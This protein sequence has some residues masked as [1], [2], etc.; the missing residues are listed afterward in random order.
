M[1]SELFGISAKHWTATES[2]V[3]LSSGL[4]FASAR[5]KRSEFE[6][7]SQFLLLATAFLFTAL[8]TT[9][10]SF[11]PIE[12][13]AKNISDTLNSKPASGLI[14]IVEIDAKSLQKLEKW[15][16]PRGYHAQLVDRL[17]EAGAA[18]IVFDVDFSSNSETTQ[19]AAFAAA[20]KRSQGRVV[21]PTFR[22]A[23]SSGHLTAEIESLP[24][25]SLREHAFLGAVNVHPD[26][27]GQVNSYPYGMIT[28]QTPRPSI[29]A[30]LAD[31]DGSMNASFKIDQSIEIDT[32][33]KHSFVD[34]LNNDFDRSDIKNKKIIVG[35]T[36]IEIGDRYP[37][38]RFGVIPGVI[39][40]T[41]AAETLLAGTALP[42]FGPWPLLI[43]ALVLFSFC[44]A[45]FS[46][47]PIARTAFT[48]A[49]LA[50]LS[51]AP[52]I[53]QRFKFAELDVVPALIMATI[54]LMLQFV[55][56]LFGKISTA[57]RVDID[58]GLPNF[59]MW[60]NQKLEEGPKAVVVAEISNFKEITSTL[61]D[62]DIMY[63]VQNVAS[64]LG[65][66][67]AGNQLFRI[68]REQF[69]WT[70]KTASPDDVENILQS[71]AHLFTAPVII[72]SRTLRAT[73][74]F[75]AVIDSSNHASALSGMAALASKKACA[76]GVRTVWHNEGMAEDNIESVFIVSE[77]AKALETGQIT[78]VYQPKF[79]IAANRVRGAEA[80]V[81]WNHP[82][83]GLI[84]PAVFVP[85][86]EQ[87]NLMEELSLF[88]LGE[89]V[90]EI[91]KWNKGPE[92]FG[93]AVNVSATL[94]MNSDFA[95]KAVKL[96]RDSQIDPG[97]ITVEL[98]ESAALSSTEHAEKMLK[99][100][101]DFGP[102]LSIDDYGTGQSTLSYL[103]KFNADEVKIDQ[104][105]VR[106]IKTDQANL[107]MVKS[108]IELARA[109]G[110]SV[111]AEGVE[112][113]T[114]FNM[115]S[116][117]GCDVIQGWYIGE[118]ETGQYFINNWVYPHP[119]ERPQIQAA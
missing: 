57:R 49:T 2:V 7:N 70:I 106:T 36:A 103:R 81:R 62:A 105:F 109:L 80:L 32:I 47:R 101:K 92:Q 4:T 8:L 65:V 10:A 24:I 60:K 71:A 28:D 44:N 15:P 79:S 45:A 54:F 33:P 69:C 75:G 119:E 21:L 5:Y 116:D 91:P 26:K 23:A 3:K 117:M 18:Q 98:T 56:D 107:I 48:V 13:A 114:V 97:L 19:D 104:S 112:D 38:S 72:G 43:I 73:I 12:R 100:V 42:Q 95:E 55:A 94:L 68:D 64:R 52:V 40:Q 67:T 89:I 25:K 74:C 37:T 85:V 11:A 16:W 63:F 30:L 93:C 41:M 66:A 82:V 29:A 115:L 78:V 84:S 22:Q 59:T 110:M 53:A 83:K 76:A 50:L 46:H 61:D 39:I 96:I 20:I 34:I 113:E 51:L 6:W 35:A 87:E 99:R 1:P 90:R 58:T 102:R 9:F 108:T 17:T 118:P 111:V 88:V 14:H 31:K 27:N 77:F 86:L